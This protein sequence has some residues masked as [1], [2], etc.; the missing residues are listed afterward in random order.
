MDTYLVTGG[1]GF[2]GSHLCD[3]LVKYAK[4]YVLD[5]L[6]T[7]RK[8]NLPKEAIFIEGDICDYQLVRS[9]MEKVN[10]CFHLAALVSVP[11]CNEN[12]LKAHEVNLT[13]TVNL[14]KTAGELSSASR[15]LPIVFASSC[16]V[17]GNSLHFPIKENAPLSPISIYGYTKLAAECYARFISEIHK[18]PLTALRLFNVYGPR[19]K[20]DS[21]YSGVISIFLNNLLHDNPCIFYGSGEQSRDFIS[22]EDVVL[23]LMKSMATSSRTVRTYNV[24]TGKST[25]IKTIANLLSQEL[26]KELVIMHKPQKIGDVECSLGDPFLAREELGIFAKSSIESGLKNLVKTMTE[27]A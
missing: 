19:Q 24:C 21:P 14:L 10:G 27:R 18:L 8:E 17:Y 26:K 5:N 13:A 16:A 23:F 20:L 3:Q 15:S 12:I 22:V 4:V 25:K 9:L 1:A 7:G 11:L 2:I 6:S